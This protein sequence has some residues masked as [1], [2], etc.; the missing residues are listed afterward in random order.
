MES[1]VIGDN[2]FEI[3]TEF[4]LESIFFELLFILDLPKLKSLTVGKYYAYDHAWED[5]S[6]EI[7]GSNQIIILYSDLPS[8]ETMSLRDSA[9]LFATN[10]VI[11]S[12]IIVHK[13]II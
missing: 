9:F 12:R 13:S 4:Q 10:I 3:A 8:L 6:V 1:I 7:K 11:S 5:I 2:S